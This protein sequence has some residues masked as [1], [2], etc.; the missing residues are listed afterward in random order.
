MSPLNITQPL[1]I[2]SIMATIRWCP[3]FPKWD[4]YQ[5]LLIIWSTPSDSPIDPPDFRVRH[6]DDTDAVEDAVEKL[7]TEVTPKTGGNGGGW[8]A[9]FF[10]GNQLILWWTF[11]KISL[12]IYIYMYLHSI[13]DIYTYVYLYCFC[14]KWGHSGAE[15][16]IRRG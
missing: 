4:S 6:G 15:V 10:K 1:G 8:M 12:V 14:H 3:I 16:A 2:W 5:P 11:A 9:G 7:L 13:I